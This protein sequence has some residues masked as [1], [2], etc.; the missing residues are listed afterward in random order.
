MRCG[1]NGSHGGPGHWFSPP[2][3]TGP[4]FGNSGASSETPQ[5]YCT[6]ARMS[7]IFHPSTNTI[8][9]ATIFGA[10]ILVGFLAWAG[11]EFYRSPYVTNVNV[12]RQQPVPF[13]HE[14]HVGGLGIDCR[15]CH[16]S[17]ENSAFAGIPSTK[18]C[19][20]CHSQVWTN[21]EMLEP[22]RASWRESKPIQWNRVHDLP[23]YAYFNHQAHVQKGVGCV[24]CHGKVDEMPLMWKTQS[25]Q[26]E[27]CLACHREPERFLRDKKDVFKL[28]YKNPEKYDDGKPYPKGEELLDKYHVHKYQLTNC[29][30]CHR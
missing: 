11:A 13:S 28:D 10:L 22:V 24:T 26:M 20:T 1:R 5:A 9:K 12:A 4:D 16:T 3:R 29:S 14:H 30:I 6:G 19:M 7:Q 27:W 25:L 23:D 17:V 21:A 18:V 15:Y 8:A 2:A